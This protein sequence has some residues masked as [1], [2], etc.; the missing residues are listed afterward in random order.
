[1]SGYIT[2]WI[3]NFGDGTSDVTVNFPANPNVSHLYNGLG[4][5]T[6]KLTVES[7]LG[8]RN[9]KIQIINPEPSPLAIFNHSEPCLSQAVQFTDLS[10]PNGGGIISSWEWNF[11]DPASLANNT[12]LLQNPAHIFSALGNYQVKLTVTNSNGCKKDTTIGVTIKP[13]PGGDFSW[14]TSCVNQPVQF[15]V[16]PILTNIPVLTAHHWDFGDGQTSDDLNPVHLYLNTGNF[17]VILTITDTSGCSSHI[18]HVL[19]IEPQPTAF[20]SNPGTTCSNDSVAFTN[21]ST[22]TYGY[23]EKWEWDFGDGSPHEIVLFPNNPNVK[24]RYLLE[25]TYLVSL[26]VTNSHGCYHTYSHDVTVIPTPVANFHYADTCA[27][28]LVHF[29]DASFPN[30]A[31]N[32]VSWTWDFGDPTSGIDNTSALQNPTHI[33]TTGN[34]TYEVRLIVVNFNNCTDT[35]IKSVFIRPAPP[36]DFTFDPTCLNK[37]VNFTANPAIMSPPTIASWDWDFGDGS[38]HSTNPGSASHLY[39]TAGVYQAVLTVVDTTGCANS[40]TK[41]VYIVPAPIPAFTFTS[42]TCD[43]MPVQFTDQSLI[44]A[45]F[46]GHITTWTWS[47]GDG[48]A[49]TISSPESPNVSHVFPGGVYHFNV[50]L[51]VTSSYGCIDSIGKPVTLIPKPT[52]AFEVAPG[53]PTCAA[54]SVQFNDLSAENGGGIISLWSWNFGDPGSGVNNISALQNPLHTFANSGVYLVTLI[55]RNLNNCADTVIKSISINQPPFANFSADTVC[56]GNPMTFTDLSAANSGGGIISHLWNFGDGN[57][58]ALVNPTNIYSVHGVY[59]VTLTVVNSNGCV[60]DTTIQTLV[61]P[62]A[63]VEFSFPGNHCSNTEICFTDHSTLPA[64]YSGIIKQWTWDFGDGTTPVTV[65][66]PANQNVCHLFSGNALT[67]NVKLTVMTSD[68]CYSSITHTVNTV[69]HPVANFNY[70]TTNCEDQ[71]VQFADLSQ[72]NGGV[73]LTSWSWDFGDPL[74]GSANFSALQNPAHIYSAQGSYPVRLIVINADNC[75]DTIEKNIVIN[76]AP[77]ASFTNSDG[78]ANGLIAFS[79]GSTPNASSIISWSWAFGDGGTSVQQNPQHLF[80]SYGVYN[81]SLTVVN[82]NGCQHDTV[83]QVT[84]SPKP[85]PGF[86]FTSPACDSTSVH[87]NDQS[88]L[89]SGTLGF[90]NKWIWTWGDGTSRTIISPESPNV[91]H[92]FPTGQY[93]F[94]V[95][96]RVVTNS[97]CTDSVSQAIQL[98]P[99]PVVS[100]EVVPGSPAC[101]NQPV[102]FNDLSQPNGGGNISGWLWNF[103]DPGSGS[104]NTSNLQNPSHIFA[105]AATYNV[106]LTVTNANGCSRSATLPVIIA[107]KPVANFVADTACAGG[108][109]QFTDASV[110]PGSLISSYAWNFG[111]GGASNLQSPLHTFASYGI[112]N[113]TLTVVNSNGCIHS[114]TKQVMVHP[115]PVP[116]FTVSEA[117]CIG[118]PVTFTDHSFLP[119]GFSGYIKKWIWNFGDGTPPETVTYPDPPDVTHTF[120]GVSTSHNVRLTVISSTNCADSLEITV[121]S[122]PSPVAN[123]SKPGATCLNQP[124]QFNDLSQTNGGGSIQSWSWN[125]GDPGSGANNF[126]TLQNPTHTFS[127]TTPYIVTLVVTSA[128]GC[129]NTHDTVVTIHPLP[130]ANFTNSSACQSYPVTFTDASTPA[131]AILSHSWNFGDGGISTLASPQHIFTSYGNFLV[132]L[133]VTDTNGCI[134]SKSKTVT[135]NPKPVVDFSVAEVRC[136]GTPVSFTDNSFVPVGYSGTISGWL[137]NFGDGNTSTDPNPVH[138]FTGVGPTYNVKLKVTL[139]TGCVDSIVKPVNLIPSPIANFSHSSAL[140]KNQPVQFTDLSLTNGGSALQSWSWNFGDPGSGTNNTS[141]LQNPS[142]IFASAGSYNVILMVENVNGCQKYDTVPITINILP[143]AGFDT[144]GSCQGNAFT[145]TNTSTANAASYTS[146]WN[147]GDGGTSILQ[148]PQHTYSA[149]GNY[150]V[151]LTIVNSNGCTHSVTKPVVVYPKPVAGFAFSPTSCAGSPVSFT[152]QSYLPAGFT[153]TISSWAWDFGDATTSTLQNPTHTYTGAASAYLVRLTV[154]S[155]RGCIGFIEKPVALIPAPVANFTHTGALCANQ[156]VQFTDLSQINGGTAIQSWSWNFDDL[157]SG[158]NN[159][160]TNQN[161]THSFSGA[162]DYHVILIVTNVNGCK[163]TLKPYPQIT[164]TARPVARFKADVACQGGYTHFTDSSTTISGTIVSHFWEFGDGTNSTAVNPSHL[165]ATTGVFNVKLTVANSLGCQKDTIIPVTVLGKPI[166][167]FTYSSPNCAGDSVQFN[168]FSTTPHGYIEKWIWNFGDGT[169]LKTV[170]FPEN[171]NVKHMFL[172]GGTFN[173]T[174]T[175]T[176]TDNCETQKVNT[177]QIGFRPYANFTFSANACPGQPVQFTDLSQLNGGPVLTNWNWN[178]GDPTSGVSNTSTAQNPTHIFSGSGAFIVRLIITNSNG[179]VDSVLNGKTVTVNVAPVA[180]FSADTS[181]LGSPTQFTD[182][183]TPAGSIANWNWNFGDPGSGV[184]N[185]STLQDPVHIYNQLGTYAVTLQVINNAQCP[186]VT[187]MP[188][189][190]SPKPTAMFQ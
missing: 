81:V 44:P 149:Y 89:P 101:A 100:F 82:S 168:D 103:G 111:D 134:H 172:N 77:V 178:F 12:S 23:I 125:F 109:T 26:T 124:V 80:V 69:P 64:G 97:G 113:V 176:T 71:Q 27:K 7:S 175:I 104:N 11:G 188:V 187:T 39:L 123:F 32:N 186:N 105:T 169:P 74:S 75:R 167:S 181:C 117:C 99:R 52:S 132:T 47:W 155:S 49:T 130:V 94:T 9:V 151:T 150:N 86:T 121:N 119:S 108:A 85:I 67:H 55:T 137:W 18:S 144:S 177:V 21:L 126:S 136:I 73:P 28:T 53:T 17:T 16:N 95:K 58:S 34:A 98:T 154:T 171:P 145:F 87:F 10:S 152:D 57:S 76:K 129:S 106:A 65:T 83:K 91:S 25:G 153:G 68:S 183:S 54:Q 148:S 179:C 35:I 66:F 174:L 107:V 48:S 102:Q 112:Y 159:T 46:P 30:G 50:W 51:T 6:V 2:Q 143:I 141:T 127:T 5:Y 14:Q 19:N 24:K 61:N 92:L 88:V 128:N 63:A 8:C 182:A 84:V 110:S 96:L 116:S 180:I 120:A 139:T 38:A 31:G 114:V 162:A 147:F 43:S 115:R 142:H 42:A 93:S 118:S 166:A 135:V 70:S 41:T 163:D 165:Y 184:N 1:S 15:T 60:K 78:C 131:P 185:T 190:V 36:V 189:T 122:I 157:L 40:L 3:W 138:T 161:P 4:P 29:T 37:L 133:T 156:P 56:A 170:I 140:C 33:F 160:S 173:V 158:A 62:I 13:L 22:T 59:N 90:I 146:S 20:F 164:T 79:D 45:G 72:L